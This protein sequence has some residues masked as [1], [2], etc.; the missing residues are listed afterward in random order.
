MIIAP[1]DPPP[2]PSR[3]KILPV[4]LRIYKNTPCDTNH[5]SMS[6]NR[7]VSA[8]KEK[9][10]RH[11]GRGSGRPTRAAVD[12]RDINH[13]G[14]IKTVDFSHPADVLRVDTFA[15]AL[16]QAGHVLLLRRLIG[17][18][19]V[20]MSR[21]FQMHLPYVRDQLRIVHRDAVEHVVPGH[22]RV[23]R[24]SPVTERPL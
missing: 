20:L 23:E 15:L 12:T 6:G 18:Q 17:V 9:L 10:H 3:P 13:A 22:V 19:W 24:L 1:P 7:K 16:R 4:E 21:R 14:G 11:I 2:P 5:S 8:N